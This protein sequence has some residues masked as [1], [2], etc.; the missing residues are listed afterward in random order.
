MVEVERHD[1]SG[2]DMIRD[3]RERV[4]LYAGVPVMVVP[5]CLTYQQT[6]DL[7][8]PANP[9]KIR[10]DGEFADSRAKAYVD[11]FGEES[12][13]LEAL[14]PSFLAEQIETHVM[15]VRDEELW[16]EALHEEITDIRRID[17]LIKQ[18]GGTPEEQ[19]DD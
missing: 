10:A 17:D 19:G 14:D 18:F 2:K 11:E 7:G 6:Q 8:L 15:Q 1:P 9:V 5:I 12:W 4:S 16:D 3:V 13:E